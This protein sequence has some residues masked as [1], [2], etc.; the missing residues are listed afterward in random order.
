[1]KSARG[2]AGALVVLGTAFGLAAA[3]APVVDHV[4]AADEGKATCPVPPPEVKPREVFE[5][6]PDIV[7]PYR[8]PQSPPVVPTATD[9]GLDLSS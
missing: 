2:L 9:L 4:C 5:T 8:I 1:M 3:P 7:W 6:V